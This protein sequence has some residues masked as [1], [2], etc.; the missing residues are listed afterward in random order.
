MKNRLVHLLCVIMCFV[1]L[2]QVAVAESLKSYQVLIEGTEGYEVFIGK[3][4]TF[5][6]TYSN[7]YYPNTAAVASAL[8]TKEFDSDL[9][10]MNNL[11]FDS[12]QLMSKGYC[13]DLSESMII[14]ETVNKMH[15]SIRDQ[16]MYDGKIY[17]I[18]DVIMFELLMIDRNVWQE[19]GLSDEIPDTMEE[20]LSFL[21][22]WCD[23]LEENPDSV[24]RINSM[25]DAAS[26]NE[27]SYTEMLTG[28]IINNYIMYAQHTGNPL[29]FDADILKPLLERAIVIGKRLY[30]N[31]PHIGYNG[32]NAGRALFV[33]S[34]SQT[35][36]Q[37]ADDIVFLRMNEEQPKLINCCMLMTAVSINTS[38][39]ELCIELLEDMIV[40]MSDEKRAFLMQGCEPVINSFVDNQL[41]DYEMR[42][43]EIDT[44]LSAENLNTSIRTELESERTNLLAECNTLRNSLY[45]MSETQIESYQSFGNALCITAPSVFAAGTEDYVILINL[46]KQFASGTIN[47]DKFLNELNRMAQ[48]IQMEL[49]E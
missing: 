42:I 13:F 22:A 48:M 28:W 23:W 19:A 36:P 38:N 33:N 49:G 27:S 3:H 7:A 24:F 15:P 47:V 31:E 18:P 20:F 35:W 10:A 30:E 29:N 12:Q 5:R 9:F 32:E 39:P 43:S 41:H 8:L 46:Q 21:E 34:Y 26:Y 37:N 1:T 45:I 16:A 25:W 14:T 40:H 17:A 4:P 44:Q 6:L 2:S 11:F